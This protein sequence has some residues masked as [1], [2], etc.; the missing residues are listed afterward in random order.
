[1]EQ[2]KR[3]NSEI[4][5][6]KLMKQQA[7]DSNDKDDKATTREMILDKEKTT[8]RKDKPQENG[9]KIKDIDKSDNDV[10][11]EKGVKGV[12]GNNNLKIG[13]WNLTSLRGKECE[14]VQEMEEY[15]IQIMGISETKKCGKG[16]TK[17]AE[18][19]TMYY[20][21]V[22][23]DHRAKEG[24]GIVVTE[25]IEKRI[26]E[27]KPKSSR[28]MYI[29]I[30]MEV[31][32]YIVQ[33]YA[34][35]EG[36]EE[37]KME[38]F[39]NE[40]QN[41][42]DEIREK[43]ERIVL[44]GDWNARIGKDEN[45]GLGCMGRH[46]EEIINRNGVKMIRFCQTNDLLIGNSFT[47][48]ALQ[49][50]YTFVAEGREAKSI[51]DYVVHTQQ[52][53]QNIKQVWTEQRAEI[54]THHRL[55]MAEMTWR[56]LV[57]QEQVEY[58]RIAVKKLK[59]EQ[60]KRRYQEETDKDFKMEEKKVEMGM[61]ERWE[62]FKE[63][64]M[65]KAEEICG[66]L[67][68]KK[69]NKKTE[70]WNADIQEE[71]RKKKKA[72]KKYNSTR[73]EQDKKEYQERRNIVKELVRKGKKE[74]WKKFGE[75]LNQNY[76][77]NNRSFWNKVK[78][79]RGK[80]RKEL[81]GV[82]DKHNQLK[83]NITEI[84]EVWREYY[85]EKY[86]GEETEGIEREGIIEQIAAN[87]NHMEEIRSEELEEAISRI[88]VGK[89]SGAD[90]ID[91]EMIKWI[92]KEGKKWLLEI[93][94]EAW[95]T[96]KMPREWED[97]LLIPIHKKGEED[98]C[99]NYRDICLSSV[100]FKLYTRIL[101]RR[102]RTEIEGKLEDEQTAFRAKRQTVDNISILRNIIEKNND[103]GNNIYITFID[104]KA[105]FDS[106]DRK[107]MWSAMEELGVSGKLLQATRS[108]Y[109]TVVGKVQMGGSR[110]GK[111]MMNKG[112]K[113]GDSLSP[114]L[115]VI[116]M[117]KLV[118]N[119]KRRT[120]HLK[121][122]VGYTHLTPVKIEGL[123]YADDVVLIADNLRK[124]QRL[125][126]VWTEE[127]EKMKLEI[128]INK[129][130]T[131]KIGHQEQVIGDETRVY[132]KGQSLEM[133]SAYEYLGTII[134][135][136]G[137]LD[138]EIANRTKKTSRIYYA[139][140]NT[141]LGKREISQETKLHVY[142]AITVPTLLYA[143]ETWVTNRKHESAIN[144]AEMKQLRKIA[145]KTKLDR[146]RS[147]NIRN[148]LRQEP[149]EKKIEKRKLNWYGH[150]TRMDENRLVKKVTEAKRQGKRRRGRPRKG[151][152]EQIQE[153]GTKRGKTVLQM[154]EMAADRKAWKKW[155]KD[156]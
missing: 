117:D 23:K 41:T 39:Y 28:I 127:M 108:T 45:I 30:E 25:E 97:N 96:N 44:M 46:G 3:K 37:E 34:P 20:S 86:M 61:E 12:R 126:D 13:T 140:N 9:K 132:C 107:E 98:M 105:A 116:V 123:L 72:W 104:L 134:S 91:P 17:I 18:S 81:R 110:S 115:F 15:K 130:K 35:T 82:R 58:S 103:Q 78:S 8:K 7:R 137:K 145:G 74:S 155:V 57:Q 33:I 93:I 26:S 128:N 27:F 133:V 29:K 101:E 142:N 87:D 94:R 99:G 143:S 152:M 62:K 148:V 49:N 122:I 38:Q 124:M 14:L 83:T 51:I 22:D 136:D 10:E 92:G 71:V 77:D 24:V 67:S 129:C 138:L 6:K 79:L 120:N 121:T 43:G 11:M 36:T 141:I 60:K 53:R 21:G 125:I 5:Y 2:S 59:D 76:R 4:Y 47:Q 139:I 50:K 119:I 73:D 153:I 109:K 131:M 63:I 147:E 151:W 100:V 75:T 113:Q 54:G 84:L 42:L 118:K 111:F 106:I 150:I 114:L 154:K 32:W 40:L 80:K 88:K 1:M 64:I 48:Q 156:G 85:E 55:V 146:E 70:W 135:N 65:K 144:A 52:M 19:C 102:L 16:K 69:S 90:K 56:K 68:I 149:I 89:A 112:I 66:N 31:E 95:R